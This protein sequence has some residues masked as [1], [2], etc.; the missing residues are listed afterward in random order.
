MQNCRVN[1]SKRTPILAT[2]TYVVDRLNI[3]NHT[4][5]WCEELCHTDKIP[6]L[7][8]ITQWFANRLIMIRENGE[9]DL[10]T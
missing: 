4:D 3:K 8:G 7:A 9:H 2:K 10:S 5:A 1:A 6:D